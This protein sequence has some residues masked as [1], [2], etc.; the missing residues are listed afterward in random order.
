MPMMEPWDEQAEP[1]RMRRGAQSVAFAALIGF[2]LVACSLKVGLPAGFGA[3]GR[4][5]GE[6]AAEAEAVPV[7]AVMLAAQQEIPTVDEC[8]TYFGTVIPERMTVVDLS[9]PSPKKSECKF[10]YCGPNNFVHYPGHGRHC[11]FPGPP[12]GCH[13]YA[14]TTYT[15]ACPVSSFSD[16]TFGFDSGKAFTDE[17]ILKACAAAVESTEMHCWSKPGPELEPCEC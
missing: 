1:S 11:K 5:L 14:K 4:A 2:G 15:E 3:A 12:F 16:L 10:G 13:R 9:A 17:G 7:A 8:S 6:G